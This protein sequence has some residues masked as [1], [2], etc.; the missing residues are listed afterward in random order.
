MTHVDG[1]RSG[2]SSFRPSVRRVAI[3]AL[4]LVAL[5]SAIL[6]T[7][8]LGPRLESTADWIA[9]ALTFR[10]RRPIAPTRVFGLISLGVATLA[11][12]VV[13]F[14][15]LQFWKWKP[16]PRF[17]LSYV[18]IFVIGAYIPYKLVWWI[19][20]FD[21]LSG[22]AVSMTF[23]FLAAYLLAVTA[24]LVLASML[25]RIRSITD[26]EVGR[27]PSPNPG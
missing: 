13:P 17:F 14:L 27:Q 7:L 25:G 19:P 4:W 12:I 22:Q 16:R 15:M 5:A 18:A 6:L 24:W 9:S 26:V 1:A 23:R 2:W 10:L 11:F 3:F 8:Q 21:N 20:E